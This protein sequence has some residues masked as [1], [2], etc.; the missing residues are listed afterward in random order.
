VGDWRCNSSGL[1]GD[2]W[3]LLTDG[4]ARFVGEARKRLRLSGALLGRRG[5]LVYGRAGRGPVSCPP[6]IQD[7]AQ[8]QEN[9]QQEVLDKEVV[10]H[11]VSLLLGKNGDRPSDSQAGD[12]SARSRYTTRFS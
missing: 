2:L 11:R 4:T 9:Y 3:G 7:A 10:Y 8:P 6:L 12:L 5:W 1:P